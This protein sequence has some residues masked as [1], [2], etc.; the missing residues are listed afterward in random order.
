MQVTDVYIN[1]PKYSKKPS[2]LKGW[3]KVTLDNELLITGIKVM[4]KDTNRFII[5]PEETIDPNKTRG[6]KFTVSIVHP[7]TTELKNKIM[8]AVF[9]K[10]DENQANHKQQLPG[11]ITATTGG[12]PFNIDSNFDGCSL[13][14]S[15]TVHHAL[16]S[17]PPTSFSI[18]E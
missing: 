17:F 9:A 4:I 12:K 10:Y 3:A 5:F 7:L 14:R 6:E 1:Y 11:I 15:D 13:G 18:S 16:S 8:N 2:V